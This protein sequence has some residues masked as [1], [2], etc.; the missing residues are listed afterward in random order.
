MSL[1][2]LSKVV[3]VMDFD[4]L[5]LIKFKPLLYVKAEHLPIKTNPFIFC[6]GIS[7]GHAFSLQISA[8]SEST[9]LFKT[10]KYPFKDE[11]A[12]FIHFL[13]ILFSLLL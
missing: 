3:P 12:R 10:K 2:K 6:Q 9:F 4:K 8:N 13:D 7:S 1:S 11:I 5:K